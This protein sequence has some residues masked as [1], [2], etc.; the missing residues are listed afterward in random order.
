MGRFH[1]TLVSDKLV[2]TVNFYEDFFGF[3]ATIEKDGYTLLQKRDDP[4]MCIAVFDTNHQCVEEVSPVQ[5]LILNLGVPNVKD[6][7]DHLYM[8]GLEF[9]K[10]FSTDKIHGG[11][12]F[13][14]RDPNGVLINVIEPLEMRALIA[15]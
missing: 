4:E 15:A 11:P 12:H 3:V 2:D 8:E 13:I 9:F 7:Y 1:A 14:V 10:D 5:G 6:L